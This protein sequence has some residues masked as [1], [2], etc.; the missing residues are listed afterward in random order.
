M[1]VPGQTLYARAGHYRVTLHAN[2]GVILIACYTKTGR[3]LWFGT[4]NDGGALWDGNSWDV[5]AVA[6]EI[7]QWGKGKSNDKRK[8]RGYYHE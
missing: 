5:A 1:S 7:E 2:A 6:R 8:T 4:L 3:K